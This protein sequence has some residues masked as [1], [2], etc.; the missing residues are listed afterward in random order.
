M[1]C[2]GSDAWETA[3]E[4]W[5]AEALRTEPLL[6]ELIIDELFRVLT[7]ARADARVKVSGVQVSGS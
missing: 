4:G 3:V 5:G 6:D 1:E 2:A 7:A